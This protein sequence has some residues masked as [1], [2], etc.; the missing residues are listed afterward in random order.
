[1]RRLA[2]L[3]ALALAITCLWGQPAASA[4]A[5]APVP[6]KAYLLRP[7]RVFDG[8][9]AREGWVVLVRGERIAA[10]GPAAQVG[11]PADA[12]PIELANT[13]LLPGL[14]EGHSH[15]LLHPY[16]ETSWND[17]VLREPLTVRVA[18][19]TNHARDALLAGFTTV[20]DLG[21]EGAAEADVGLKQAIRQGIIPG[22]RVVTTTRAIVATGTYAPR[23]FAP[24]W[25]VP[26]G[27]EEADGEDLVRVVRGQIARGADWIKVYGDYAWGPKGEALP[28]FSLAEMQRIVATARDGRRPVVVHASTPEGMK[29]AVLAGAETIEHGDGGTAEV[30]KLMAKRGV[31][32]CPTLA[33]TDAVQQYAG[34]K[35]GVGP[36]PQAIRDKRA[37]FRA[38]LTAGVPICF[39]SDVGVFRH[40]DNARELELMVDYGMKPIQALRAATSVNARMLHMADSIGQVKVGL[41]ADLVAVEGDPTRTISAVRQV[42]F[43][44]KGGAIHRR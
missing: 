36:E 35:P 29:R 38:A 17:Q 42:R 16:D 30:F 3:A 24:A 9:A 27:A 18:R 25:H 31:Y 37:S 10:V 43:V 5:P 40:G 23:G 6:D 21:T 41:L 34:W 20:R 22:P 32:L 19:A 1:M 8:E 39:G 7:A 4:A 33:A 11:V 12:E 28:T 13:T 15:L 14:I 26:Q 44:M 2:A